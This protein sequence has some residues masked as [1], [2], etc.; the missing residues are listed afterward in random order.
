MRIISS[1]LD[2]PI[3]LL[4]A[5]A[6]F[7]AGV[8]PH[9]A[10]Q[11]RARSSDEKPVAVIGEEAIYERDYLPQIQSQVYKIRTQE[12]ELKL[13]ALENAINQRANRSS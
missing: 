4:L 6:W 12:Y 13:K 9:A 5:F 3:A 10:A 2:R 1:S 8:L 7:A 11:T